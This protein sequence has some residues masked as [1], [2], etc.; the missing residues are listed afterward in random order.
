MKI[1]A[2]I[3]SLL[4]V[5]SSA[6]D[7]LNVEVNFA[8]GGA[9]TG[10]TNRALECLGGLIADCNVLD[11][12]KQNL[13]SVGLIL[14]G[15]SQQVDFASQS[16]TDVQSNKKKDMFTLLAGGN[17]F[18]GPYPIWDPAVDPPAYGEDFP[19][20][21]PPEFVPFTAKW[22]VEN[23]EYAM[24]RIVELGGKLILM[25]ST[26]EP[27]STLICDVL[28]PP[29]FQ[30]P[31]KLYSPVWS[32]QFDAGIQEVVAKANDKYEDVTVIFVDV[33]STVDALLASG[34]FIT[35]ISCQQDGGFSGPDERGNY[36]CPGYAWLDLTHPTS[37][38]WEAVVDAAFIPALEAELSDK[39]I[40]DIRRIISF[41][42]SYADFGSFEDTLD[43]ADSFELSGRFPPSNRRS[44]MNAATYVEILEEKLSV[45]YPSVA[46]I[47]E[48]GRD[49]ICMKEQ[50]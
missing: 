41:G 47:Q 18:F 12:Y 25:G 11:Q 34:D 15:V 31:V 49:P 13:D 42:D 9:M 29:E 33:V 38:F 46:Y 30:I 24:E 22:S 28:Q 1:V 17:D 20:G 6:D 21:F 45:S 16:L 5:S 27:C 40:K 14:P 35:D 23:L 4:V 37:E 36:A 43:R 50:E 44:A 2:S 39:E 10:T 32:G 8:F 19:D 26:L 3:L 48:S 7:C